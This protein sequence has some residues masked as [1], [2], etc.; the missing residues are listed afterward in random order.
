MKEE[1]E[2]IVMVAQNGPGN[3]TKKK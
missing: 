1:T 3:P 2:T